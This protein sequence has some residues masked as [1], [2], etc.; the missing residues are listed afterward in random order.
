MNCNATREKL[1]Q[2]DLRDE[3]VREHLDTCR[4][5][6][7]F[8]ARMDAVRGALGDH[9]AGMRPDAG[10]SARV[11]E[12][13]RP[14]HVSSPFDD[15]GWAAVRMLPAALLLAA[16]T[17]WTALQPHHG[18]TGVLLPGADDDL[19]AAFVISGLDEEPS[20]KAIEV[21]P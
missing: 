1:A 13:I 21:K 19:L 10:F 18:L 5:C 12:Q 8:A 7:A 11:L 15:L 6:R 9:H 2:L 16:F 3:A 14:Q 4:D 20:K 17:A